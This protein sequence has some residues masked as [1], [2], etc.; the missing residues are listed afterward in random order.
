MGQQRLGEF[1]ILRA[2]LAT[3]QLFDLAIATDQTLDPFV[4]SPALVGRNTPSAEYST[5]MDGLGMLLQLLTERSQ[6]LSPFTLDQVGIQ[7]SAG[8]AQGRYA[9]LQAP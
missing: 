8:Q 9:D 3:Q 5:V 6:Q 7:S 4:E 2:D 1:G